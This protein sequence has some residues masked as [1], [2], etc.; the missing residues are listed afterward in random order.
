MLR[1]LLMVLVLA[2]PALAQGRPFLETATSR[3]TLDLSNQAAFGMN[4]FILAGVRELAGPFGLRGGLGLSVEQGQTTFGILT[5]A[6]FSFGRPPLIPEAG[7]GF[8]ASF[9][10]QGTQFAIQIFGGTEFAINRNVSLVSGV[11]PEVQFAG[12][13]TSFGISIRTGLRIYP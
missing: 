1:L 8:R 5:G 10:A 4:L 9:G 11:E 2:S 3:I 6:I 7:L 13:G 12:G